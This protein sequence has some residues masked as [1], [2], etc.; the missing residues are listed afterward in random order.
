MIVV[1]RMRKEFGE[2]IHVCKIFS[3]EVKVA[4]FKK[5]IGVIK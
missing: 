1:L 4:A 5:E 3:R 2:Y